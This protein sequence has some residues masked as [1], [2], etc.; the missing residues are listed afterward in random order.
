MPIQDVIVVPVPVSDQGRAVGFYV[1]K[2]GLKLTR[3]E[4]TLLGVRRV[5]VSANGTIALDLVT[6]VDSM[7]PGSLRGLV[8]RTANLHADYRR[9]ASAGVEFDGPPWAAPGGP[10]EAVCYDPDGNVLIL[11]GD[12][13]DRGAHDD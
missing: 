9:L 2:L 3:D 6:W 4:Q 8:F 13:I 7:P 12:S 1:G 5:Q 10:Y 11:Q